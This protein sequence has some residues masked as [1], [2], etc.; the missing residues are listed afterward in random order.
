[1]GLLGSLPAFPFLPLAGFSAPLLFTANLQ[2]DP[3]QKKKV[4]TASQQ[5]IEIERV[6]LTAKHL[7]SCVNKI[8]K[9][10]GRGG[11][12]LTLHRPWRRPWI[13][14]PSWWIPAETPRGAVRSA[15]GGANPGRN[16]ARRRR[17]EGEFGG[18]GGS[19]GR[20]RGSLAWP[21]EGKGKETDRE[22]RPEREGIRRRR[23][24]RGHICDSTPPPR[25]R[26]QL[27]I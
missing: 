5:R 8:A 9:Q 17:I 20:G 13:W 14:L 18:G 1:L 2:A 10:T 21:W 22:R 25:A 4:K 15:R 19:P 11:V 6:S 7:A 27:L 26:T 3:Q 16:R 23:A 12:V 24:P